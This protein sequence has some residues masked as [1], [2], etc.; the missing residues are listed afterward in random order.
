MNKKRNRKRENYPSGFLCVFMWKKRRRRRRDLKW[1]IMS[2]D[3][4]RKKREKY[5]RH[6]TWLST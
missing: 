1:A 6:P 5:I 4:Y 2:I 3:R